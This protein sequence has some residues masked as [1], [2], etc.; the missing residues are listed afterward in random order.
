MNKLKYTLILILSLIA[1]V[2]LYAQDEEQPKEKPVRQM[3]GSAYLMDNQ[4]VTVYNK[5]TFEWVMQHRFGT[6][7]NGITDLFGI[8]GIS[9]IR[10]GFTYVPINKLSIGYGFTQT[11]MYQDFNVKYAI[12]EQTR[13]GKI[14]VSITY[15]GSMAIDAR[16]EEDITYYANSTDRLSYFNQLIIARKVT[17]NLSIQLAPSYTHF[18]AV[19]AMEENGEVIALREHDHFALAIGARYKV[20]PQGSITVDYNVPLTDHPTNNPESNYSFGY[21]IVTSSHAFQLFMGNY[22]GI[23]PQENNFNSQNTEFLLGFNITRLWSF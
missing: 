2:S 9:N 6:V 17:S 14:P 19:P 22:M 16:A 7:E 13:S 10:M 18:N 1:V 21:E 12:I 23:V 5:G 3:F 11:K 8:Y 20:S 15:F 4:S